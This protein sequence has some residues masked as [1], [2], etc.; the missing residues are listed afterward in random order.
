MQFPPATCIDT[1]EALQKLVIQLAQEPLLA[2][3]TE[4][5][6]MYAYR[7]RV[8]LVQISTRSADYII[9]PLAGVD[10]SLLAPLMADPNIEKVFHAAEYD[11]ICLTRDYGFTF[12]N[13]FDTM[14]AA[15]ICG[16]KTIGLAYLLAEHCGVE[17]DKSHQRDDWGQRPLSYESLRYAQMDTHYLPALRDTLQ[18]RL[19]SLKRLDEAREAFID[20]CHVHLPERDFDPDGYWRIGMPH[21]LTRREMAILRELYLL[22]EDIAQK[23]DAPAFKVFSN[24]TLIAIARYQPR[25][26]DELLTIEGMSPLMVRRYGHQLLTATEHGRRAKLPPQPPQHTVAWAVTERYMALHTWRKERAIERGVESDVIISKDTLWVLAR[27]APRTLDGLRNIR[28]LGPWR[29]QAYGEEILRVLT[30]NP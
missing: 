4:S 8:C 13:L 29:L 7:E 1:T 9:D 21:D 30:Q 28:G 19:E 10:M 20:A 14:T 15:R 18:A 27:E 22:R 25:N 12:Y 17:I 26:N 2:I 6:S 11:L 16:Y 23:R 3:D 5:N 24:R